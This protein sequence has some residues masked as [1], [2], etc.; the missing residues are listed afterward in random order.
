M[1]STQDDDM[2]LFDSSFG[3]T[4]AAFPGQAFDDFLAGGTPRPT[5]STSATFMNP[6]DLAAKQSPATTDTS[7]T[8]IKQEN[9]VSQSGSDSSSAHS[10]TNSPSVQAQPVPGTDARQPGNWQSGINGLTMPSGEELFGNT[11]MTGLEDYEA[12]NQ[13]MASDF[14][15]ETAASTPSAFVSSNLSNTG[16]ATAAAPFRTS[17]SF[18]SLAQLKNAS[19]RLPAGPGHFYFGNSRETSPMN[20]MLP[21][22]GQSPWAKNSPSS[23]LEET[24]NGITMNGDSPGNATFSPNL[25]FPTNGFNFDATD[26][27]T[28]PST[29]NKDLSSPPSTANSADS[30]SMLMVY[31]TSLKSRV[32]TQIPI[33]MT[34]A[35]LPAGATK[36]RLPSYTVSKPKFLAKP[37]ADRSPEILE[38][39]TSLVCTSAMQDQAKLDRAFARARGEDVGPVSK[40]SPASSTGS[41][42]SKDDEEKPLNGGE[43]K[44]CSGCIQRERKRASRKKQKK[45]DE[46]EMFQKDEEKRVIVFNTNE[47]KEWAEPAKDTPTSLSGHQGNPPPPLP[48]GAMQVELPMRIACYCRHQNEKLGFQVIFTIKDHT[49]KVIAQAMTNSI[50]ITDDH[51]THNAPQPMPTSNP[52]L[53]NAPQLPG[54]GVFSTAGLDLSGGQPIGSKMFKQSLSTTDLQGLQ[55]NFNP[56]F[57]MNSSH[58][59]FAV[60]SMTSSATLT[61]RN[62]S[63]PASPT[64]FSGPSKRRKQSGSGKIPSGLTMTRLETS[65]PHGG[66]STMPNTATASSF[67]PNF[68]TATSERFP[69]SS[70]QPAYGTSPP[71][72]NSNDNGFMSAINRSFSMENLPRQAMM[73]APSS[74]QPSRPGSPG[75]HR[76][77]FSA[78]QNTSQQAANQL[79]GGQARRPPPL[80]HKLVP[81]EGSITGGTEVTLLGNGFYQGLEVMFGD[82][83]ATTTT[84]WGEKCLNCITPPSL[85][86]GTVAVVFKHE[87]HQYTS[88][89]QQSQSRHFLFTYIDDREVEMYRLALKT[90]GK[91][92]QHPTEDP[93]SAAQQLLG[94]PS[95]SFW[96][97]TQGGYGGSRGHQRQARSSAQGTNLVELESNM[98]KFLD[99]LDLGGTATPARLNT[100]RRSGATLLHLASSLGLTRFVAGLLSRGAN[101]NALDQNGNTPLHL[102]AMT[103]QPNIIYRLRLAGADHKI[104]C[105]RGFIPADLALSLRVHQAALIPQQRTFATRIQSRRASATSLEWD[106]DY[107]VDDSEGPYSETTSRRSS[108]VSERNTVE[109]KPTS[110]PPA[111]YMSAWRD[112]LACQIQHFHEIAGWA[113]P[114]LTLPALPNLPDYQAHSV[115]RRV[116]SLFPQRPTSLEYLRTLGSAS[117]TAPPAYDDLYPKYDRNSEADKFSLTKAAVVQATADAAIDHHFDALETSSESQR[118]RRAK[119]AREQQVSAKGSLRGVSRLMGIQ[120]SLLFGV[121]RFSSRLDFE[122]M[123]TDFDFD[124]GVRRNFE[125]YL[126][127]ND[128][129]QPCRQLEYIFESLCL[130][131]IADCCR[132]TE[133]AG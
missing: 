103:G 132:L 120:Y 57:P 104:K 98:L 51:K 6:D 80:I 77:S 108:A 13:Q 86:A 79:F 64:G 81:A 37:E 59:P 31:P 95:P 121:G 53:P 127:R 63:R 87:H 74:R 56:N 24:F 131:P 65:Q 55:H 88:M 5:G 40:P 38:L 25:Q 45:P 93:Y 66:S 106:S 52:S 115:V 20:T 3:Q 9:P 84:F 124:D 92:M 71:T 32:E 83:E 18:N 118:D 105:I 16:P 44:I 28:T 89:Q 2:Y 60:P 72:P 15:F 49:E 133:E 58:N 94:G 96:P 36:L 47:I 30:Q 22:S 119:S 54:A 129:R 4:H 43:V 123:A 41:Q 102:A 114:N 109:G 42:C 101:P 11:D 39:S 34:L 27:S 26:S 128:E 8:T 130:R 122:L 78:E 100:R 19:P 21:A 33:K 97:S 75:A 117:P 62:L 111:H 73:S 29:F 35:P 85:Q 17:V 116:S 110:I 76:D 50:M 82:S 91:Q 68:M 14:D 67:A 90:V 46:E 69:M 10:S 70:R 12:S 112:S 126:S 7:R 125:K 48:K 61:P 113:M 23:G 99:Y 107:V 1:E